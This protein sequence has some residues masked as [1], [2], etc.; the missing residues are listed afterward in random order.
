M[1]A[2]SI[3]I[4]TV[5]SKDNVNIL[6]SCFN[7]T[8]FSFFERNTIREIFTFI[9]RSITP[10]VITHDEFTIFSYK[11]ADG[12]SI[13]LICNNKYPSRT[14]F[15]CI[16]EVYRTFRDQ[17]SGETLGTADQISLKEIDVLLNKYKDPLVSDAIIES[18]MK[19][20]RAKEAIN[21]SLKSFLD[22]GEN[23]DELIQ[24]SSDL[25]ESSKKLFK[26]SKKAKRSCC[27]FQ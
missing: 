17:V 21:T 9:V 27:S 18:Q 2:Y 10:K 26:L 3:F 25:S 15:S 11:W 13:F 24:K 1:K 12:V 19:I 14:A 20:N 22:R 6:L 8:S 16:N 5:E 4:S 23:L 7:L